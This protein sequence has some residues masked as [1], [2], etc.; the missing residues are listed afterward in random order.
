M[1]IDKSMKIDKCDLIDVDC[2]DQ[3]VEIN[4]TLVFYRFILIFTDFIVFHI[5]RYI[6]SSVYQKV[7][8]DLMQTVNLLRI[9]LKLRVEGSNIYHLFIKH[10]SLLHKSLKKIFSFL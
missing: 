8:T 6:S 7:K 4:G 2:I 1:L 5:G 10:L 3:L 9:E